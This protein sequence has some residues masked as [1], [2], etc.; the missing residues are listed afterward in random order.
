MRDLAD[1]TSS[2]DWRWRLSRLRAMS[3]SEI[4]HRGR[5]TLRDRWWPPGHA[6]WSP[7]RAYR[8]LFVGD[9][10]AAISGSRLSRLMRAPEGPDA[11]EPEIAAATALMAG[12]WTLFG[13]D[14]QLSDPP[15]WSE[16]ALTRQAWPDLPSRRLDHRTA[17]LAGGARYVWEL[18]RLTVLPTLAVAYGATRDPSFANL[19]A[20]WLDDW[21][22]RQPLGRG[23]H[24]AS[25]LEMA[26]RVLTVCSTLALLGERAAGVALAPCL[27]LLAQQALYCRDHLS[28]GS[29]ANN[30]LIAEYA[31]MAVMGAMFPALRGADGLLDAGLDGLQAETLR[32]FHPDG[33]TAEQ[34]FGYL[35]FV[36]ELLLCGLRAAETAG[37]A[38]APGTRRRLEASI[39]FARAIRLPDGRCPQVGD[40]DDGGILLVSEGR[41]RLDLVGN[42]LAAWLGSEALSASDVALSR[43]LVGRASVPRV[44]GEGAHSYP[45]G[46][47]T[48]WRQ[49]ET[50]VTFDHGPLGLGSLAAHGH[51]DALSLTV[52]HGRDPVVIDPGTYAYHEDLAGRDRF[53]GTPYHSTVHFGGRSQSEMRGPFLW[54]RR[55]E[56]RPQGAGFVCRWAT[57]ET[58]ERCVEVGPDRIQVL[59]QVSGAD[60]ELVWVLAP[61]ARV[62][63]MGARAVVEVGST[64]ATLEADRSTE[65]RLAPG[66]HSPRFGR[67]TPTVR[68]TARLTAP[69]SRTTLTVERA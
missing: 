5:V 11:V 52:F 56:V 16:N 46:G 54:G 9:A 45:D 20:R 66:E 44:A 59:D 6:G 39:E 2:D 42:A 7:A 62:R 24:Y 17:D 57:G 12:R 38:V 14:V 22:A 60:A 49:G 47:Y 51:A 29:S 37:R 23:I 68:L 67:T 41:R 18:G 48:V 69:A 8:E 13:H 43:L 10:D 33:V 61:E 32:Q 53:R 1:R 36:W 4:W 35:P 58:H 25:G 21:S 63:V 27:G 19:A 55:A 31:A 26:I 30:H 15:A 3:S 64:R 65:W 28:R 50:V 34:A 40:G